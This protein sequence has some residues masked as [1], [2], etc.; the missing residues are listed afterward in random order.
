[1]NMADI[2]PEGLKLNLGCGRHTIHGWYC[3]D[4]VRHP[5]AD[6]DPDLI[7]D[8]RKVPLPDACA[9]ELLAI[10]VF[11]HV[12][13][14]EAEDVMTEWHRL[15]RLGGKLIME[16]PDLMKF[17]HNIQTGREEGREGQMG[18]WGMYGDPTTKDPYMMHKW[19]WTYNS[20]P[21]SARIKPFLERHGFHYIAEEE[22]QWHPKGR[23]V[24]DFRV[25]ARKA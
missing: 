9:V 16:M 1:M 3:V 11:E 7:G 2:P 22:T 20:G 19:A 21:K 14:W 13:P 6:R 17:I 8:F 25:T 23:G 18:M 5:E 10:H 12:Y 24:R 15:L 4:I